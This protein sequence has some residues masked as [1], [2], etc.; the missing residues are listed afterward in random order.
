MKKTIISLLV[1]FCLIGSFSTEVKAANTTATNEIQQIVKWKKE[2]LQLG[3][4]PLLSTKFLQQAA[5]SSADWYVVGIGRAGL[6]DEYA[7][8]TSVVADTIEKRYKQ[9]GK[10]SPSKATEWQRIALAYSAAGGDATNIGP[11]HIN[12]ISDGVY[13]RGKTADLAA[14]GINGLIWG[15]ITVDTMRYDIPKNAFDNRTSII[16][17]IIK[18]Q[19]SSGGFSLDGESDNIDITAMTITALAPYYNSEKKYDSNQKGKKVNVRNVIDKALT[20]LSSKQTK[21]GSYTASGKANLESNAQVIVALTSLG[22]D[23]K[24]D[25]RFIKSGH[26]LAQVLEGFRQEDG[27]Y[28]HSEIYDKSNKTAK[29]DTSNSMASEQALYA[30]VAILRQE[31]GARTLFDYREEQS[32]D[33]KK[34]IKQV[35]NSI[36]QAT[37]TAEK[38][39]AYKMYLK[40]PIEERSYIRN[41]SKIAR[42]DT[43]YLEEATSTSNQT[44]MSPVQL[45]GTNEQS[46][47]MFTKEDLQRINQ[48]PTK[49]STQ[50]YVTVVR[51]LG[52]LKHTNKYPNERKKLTTRLEKIEHLK[53]EIA[54]LN[55]DIL[56][57]LYPFSHITIEDQ[58]KVEKIMTRYNKLASYDQKQIISYKDVEKS[59]EQITSLK[60][61]K[62][63]KY[64]VVVLVVFALIGFIIRRKRKKDK[65]FE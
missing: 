38:T 56:D 12:L 13:N 42:T 3:N 26:N 47:D 14:Q 49:I 32:E 5:N 53:K 63:L 16:T 8:Y 39:T 18:Q 33:L 62:W 37:T 15:L 30:Y 51:L 61:E 7:A 40:I 31:K 64:G 48:L 2:A 19:M 24:K 17:R 60:R 23:I 27:G 1:I 10:L 6:T 45:L 9:P 28:I 50:D 57:D 59:Q 11:N 65:E 52:K 35:E 44:T 22:I 55:V 54:A 46:S 41:Y 43:Y 58:A 20:Y 34:Q 36:D 4:Q 29:P 21:E 25:Q